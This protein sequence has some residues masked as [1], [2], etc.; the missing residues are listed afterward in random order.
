MLE[1][2]C[3]LELI[4]KM[5]NECLFFFHYLANIFLSV[6]YSQGE[7]SVTYFIELCFLLNW[8]FMV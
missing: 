6:Y 1:T 2:E 3:E 4:S 5:K 7:A 8:K